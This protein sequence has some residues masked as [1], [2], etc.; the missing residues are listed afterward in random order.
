MDVQL[1]IPSLFAAIAMVYGGLAIYGML[2]KEGAREP[3]QK[4]RLRIALIFAAVSVFLF[5]YL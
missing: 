2:N 4:T 3:A 1:W 5:F